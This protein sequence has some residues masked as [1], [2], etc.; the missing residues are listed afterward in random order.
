MTATGARTRFGRVA[1]LVRTAYVVSSQQKAVLRVVR[2]L[3]LFS[4]GV[5]VFLVAYVWS[6]K[7]PVTV[8]IALLDTAVPA[9]IPVALPA[10]FTLAPTIGARSVSF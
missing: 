4:G 9:S 10:T 7:L 1:E 2:N 6:I 5:I 8:L 3:A